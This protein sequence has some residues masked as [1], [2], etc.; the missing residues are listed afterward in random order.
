MVDPARVTYE[1]HV[2]RREAA[3]VLSTWCGVRQAHA[4][5]MAASDALDEEVGTLSLDAKRGTG[6]FKVKPGTPHRDISVTGF[7]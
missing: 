4:W 2:A 6:S 5:V 3:T 1:V 7:F